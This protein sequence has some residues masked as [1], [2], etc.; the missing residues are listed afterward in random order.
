MVRRE[1]LRLKLADAITRVLQGHAL[2]IPNAKRYCKRDVLCKF[3]IRRDTEI[4][5]DDWECAIEIAKL[6]RAKPIDCDQKRISTPT[7]PPNPL[8]WKVRVRNSIT[9]NTTISDL[10]KETRLKLL[11]SCIAEEPYKTKLR[12][13]QNGLLDTV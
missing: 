11:D 3:S 8:P 5:V 2:T 4:T 6:R 12:A 13:W 7:T 1:K 9:A 10:E